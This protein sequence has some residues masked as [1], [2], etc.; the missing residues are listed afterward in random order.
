MVRS[1]HRPVLVSLLVVLW[2]ASPVPASEAGSE[3]DPDP[4][5]DRVGTL[6]LSRELDARGNL[7][8]VTVDRLGFVYVS[9][10]RDAVW[11]ISPE[12]EVETLTRSLYGASGNAVDSRGDLVQANFLGDTITR[13]A[14]TGEVRPFVTEGLEG[15][16]GIAV[17]PEDD[18]LYVC[19]CRGNFLSRVTP[20]GR[21]ERFAESERF[22]CPNGIVFGPDGDLFV[23]N[24]NHHDILRVTPEGDVSVFAT[25]PGGAGNAHLTF[26]KGFF[27]VTKI[28]ANRVVKVSPDGEVF[29][30]AGTGRP[31]HEDGPGPEATFYRPNGIA[32]S[33]SGDRLYVNTLVGEYSVPEPSTL[34]VRTIELAT[35]TGVLEQALEAGGV[36]AL[37][38][39]YERFSSHPVRG[40]E[41]TVAEMVALGY[42][43]LSSRRIPEALTVFRLN[44]EAHPEAPA[45]QYNL[46]EA[47]RYTGRTERAIEQY[48]RVLE[49]DP[50]HE[51]AASRLRQLAPES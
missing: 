33:P 15:P 37:A 40:S 31:G 26:A 23:T 2:I 41:D 13:I 4:F 12:G 48:E 22:A 10:F 25:V 47:F 3:A 21:A 28:I 11:R 49:L 20:D 9:N 35:L 8:G 27:Y 36:E 16:V 44:A 5:V 38:A 30:V 14:R 34:T 43:F 24:F 17:D 18:T 51:P 1:I 29:P 6:P 39:A 7:G 46:G 45:A 50:G 32:V 42:R 19:N